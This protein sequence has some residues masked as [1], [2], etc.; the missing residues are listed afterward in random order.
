MEASLPLFIIT[1][2]TMASINAP[3]H[4]CAVP[5]QVVGVNAPMCP[6]R[7]QNHRRCH[8]TDKAASPISTAVDFLHV[9]V[10]P[11]IRVSL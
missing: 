8:R 2:T 7:R 1:I 5:F 11:E 10:N 3:P 6:R 9:G 4:S